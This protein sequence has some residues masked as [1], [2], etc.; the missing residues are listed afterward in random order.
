MSTQL[1]VVLVLLVAAIV[2]FAINKPR[3]D[4]VALIMLTVLPFTGVITMGEALAGFS[5]PNIVLI[6]ALFVIGDGLVRTGVAQRLGDWLTAKAGQQRDAAA[7]PADARRV[8]TRRDDEFDRRHGD[9]HSGRA[10]DRAEHRHGAEP[11]DDAAE[12][13]RADQRHDDA[14]RDRAESGRQQRA[15]PPRRRQ[16]FTSS[17]SR[18]SACRSWSSASST[19]SL[20]AAGC[21]RRTT[22]TRSGRSRPSLAD[23]IEEYKLADREHRVRVTDR[24]PLVGKTLEELRPARHVRRERRRHR[25][26]P[27]ILARA[28][29]ARP[30][31]P[32]CGPATSCSSTCSRANADVEALAADNT[33]WRSCRSAAPTSPIGRRRSAWRKSSCR[34]T[35]TLVGKT[36]VEAGFRTDYGLTVIG[37]RRGA[38]ALEREPAGREA[39]RS[40]T[41][42][43]LIGPWKDIGRLQSDGTDLVVAQPAGR[44]RRSAAGRRQGAAGGRLPAARRRAD[45]QRRR[46]ERAG[47][48]DRL[49]ADGRAGLRRSEQRLSSIDWKTIVLIVGMLPFSTRA[50]SGPAASIWRPTV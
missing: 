50:A 10:A 47:G 22:Q 48:P 29:P 3:M 23:W 33:R 24:S 6:A 16:G 21:R 15:G 13:R 45:G 8:R 5:D 44:A 41:R 32:N 31:T 20:R 14:G 42:C 40:A 7:R 2:M 9:L 4:A 35:R 18:R 36:V 43:W 12:L 17:A 39:A 27:Q 38:Q 30:R 1:A 25:A 26:Q 37:L 28:D 49:P 19:C 34:P 11:A 46:A